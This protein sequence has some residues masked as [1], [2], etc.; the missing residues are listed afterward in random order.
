MSIVRI[1][2]AVF[3]TLLAFVAGGGLAIAQPQ[4]G[5]NYDEGWLCA[6]S[7]PCNMKF[8]NNCATLA[9]TGSCIRCTGTS[10]LDSF[11]Y[12]TGISEDSCDNIATSAD[13]G[14]WDN[15]GACAVNPN[16]PQHCLCNTV[17]VPSQNDCV[18]PNCVS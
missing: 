13:C 12:Y 5:I 15:S 3:L 9:C 14:K 10:G 1:T 11:C 2:A 18:I 7:Q 6:T 4:K 8:R 17:G 16:D